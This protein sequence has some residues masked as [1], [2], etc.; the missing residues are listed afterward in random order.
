MWVIVEI[1]REIYGP[2][3]SHKTADRWARREFMDF[4]PRKIRPLRPPDTV[5]VEEM[6]GEQK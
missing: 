4:V 1:N 2:F 6:A 3:K 5:T